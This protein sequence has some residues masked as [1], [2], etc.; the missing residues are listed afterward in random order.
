MTVGIEKSLDVKDLVDL[1]DIEGSF[2]GLCHTFISIEIGLFGR[3]S[4]YLSLQL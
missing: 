1:A 2:K 4:L 3:S